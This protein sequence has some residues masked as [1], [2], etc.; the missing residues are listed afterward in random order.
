ME[1]EK[2]NSIT[3]GFM[4]FLESNCFKSPCFVG[5]FLFAGMFLYIAI[6]YLARAIFGVFDIEEVGATE[7]LTYLFYGFGGGILFCYAKDFMEEPSKKKSFIAIAFLY[8]VMIFRDMGA[9]GWFT[10][11]DTVITKIRFFTSATNPM[12]EKVIAAAVMLFILAVFLYVFIK[13]AKQF[14]Q[15]LMHKEPISWTTGVFFVWMVIT[16]IFDRFPAEYQKATGVAL[17]EPVRFIMKIVEEGGESLLPLM[18]AVA[19][20]QYH[21]IYYKKSN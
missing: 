4:K 1:L 18:I 3:G 19:I 12:Y 8:I 17:I 7:I 20:L 6:S 21:Y 11:H 9:Q 13:H 15:G 2:E 5:A 14:F 16:Q 10:T